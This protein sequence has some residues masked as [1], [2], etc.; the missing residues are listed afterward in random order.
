MQSCYFR[1]L[2]FIPCLLITLL[3]F[4]DV[5]GVVPGVHI[6]PK[7]SWLSTCKPYNKKPSLRTV[8][9]GYF[10]ELVEHQVQVEKQANYH[11]L[12]RE[13]V[14]ETGIQNGSEISVSFDPTFERL[15]FHEITVW[16][17]NKPQNRL[18]TSAF[19]VLADEKDLSNF[20]YQGTYSALCI[21]DDI[22]K[23]DRIEYSYTITGRN[24]IFSNKY[25]DFLY[26]QFDQTIEHQYTSLIFSSQRKLNM[27]TFN[28][29]SNPKTSEADGLK[30]YEW[31]DFQVVPA[32][33][34]DNSP[35]WYEGR[36]SVQVTEFD[37]WGAVADWAL[38]INEPATNITGEL[39]GEIKKLKTSS[40]DDKEKYFRSAV[41]LVQNE[42]RY[43]GIEIGQ[44]SH[45]ANNPEKVFKQRYGDCKDKSLLLV[46]ILRANGIDA[47]MVL[48][49]TELGNHVA[50]YLP[51]S[52][53][54]NH[55]VVIV[56]LKGKEVW[57]D[58]TI[59]DQ[60]GEGTAIYFP[61]YGAGL[62]LKAGATGLTTV[63]VS[64][65]GQIICEEKYLVKDE[66]SPVELD[67][68]TTYT[69]NEADKIRDRL[70]SAGMAE[71]EK[72]YLDYYAKT[73]SKIE[74]KDSITLVDDEQKNI[75]TT[76]ERYKITDY[77]KRDS[78][79][80]KYSADF[81]ADFVKEQFPSITSQ[82]KTPV[83]VNYPFNED[84]TIKMVLT[85]GWDITPQHK[86]IARDAYKFSSDYSSSGDTLS[87]NYKF[88]Y[89]KEFVP[90]EKLDEFKQDIKQ[91]TENEL[92]YNIAIPG[93]L[94]NNGKASD[95]NQWMLNLALFIILALG[96]AGVLIYRIETPGIVFSY[97]ST[98]TPIGGWLILVVIGLVLTPVY[99]IYNMVSEEYFNM[100]VWNNFSTYSYGASL[101]AH[102]AFAVAGNIIIATLA[103]FCLVL[104]LNRRDILPRAII[105][106]FGFALLF[107]IANFIF[108][109]YVSHYKIPSAYPTSVLRSFII[110]AIWITYFIKSTRVQETFIVPYPS[111]NYSYESSP[112]QKDNA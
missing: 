18:K 48:I 67:V 30:R 70:S 5:E 16:R 41:K 73:Y 2:K 94:G 14:S 105:V 4:T 8:E 54:F 47:H 11:H 108:I 3:N 101:K 34:D 60:G 88:A 37:S 10:F 19:K 62:V 1:F 71:T 63:P 98:F 84:Y 31:E 33:E 27:K 32:I 65:A 13:I 106:Y 21:L 85:T 100:H 77:F 59:D 83:S 87:L 104:F 36:A 38:G 102:F 92:G 80:G 78:V 24:P 95:L 79:T 26:L 110:A 76:I 86:E 74:A 72:N 56:D 46:S 43:M 69:L 82:T 39:G 29:L 96:V 6:L 81:Y 49:N 20:I 7:P 53:L 97:G 9:G 103:V 23:G 111:C 50:Q 61:D 91:L 68:K 25:C 109:S 28:P 15:D 52:N 44:Y 57:V 93:T 75:L 89:L 12:I 112:D 51:G 35:S 99:I 45:R 40:G 42:V 22:R 107:N 90:I 58:A 55:A 64:P 17:D 66:K